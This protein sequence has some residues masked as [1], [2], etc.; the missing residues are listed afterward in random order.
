MIILK[1]FFYPGLGNEDTVFQIIQIRIT[2]SVFSENKS[3][4]STCQ[5]LFVSP[6]SVT[7]GMYFP[8]KLKNIHLIILYSFFKDL[9]FYF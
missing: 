2:K 6:L 3:L 7:F 8:E 1:T 9:V 5:I 4:L